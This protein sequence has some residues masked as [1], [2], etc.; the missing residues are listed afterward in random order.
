MMTEWIP[1][2]ARR[3]IEIGARDGKLREE[4]LQIR[5]DCSYLCSEGQ[6]PETELSDRPVDCFFYHSSC[7]QGADLQKMLTHHGE[8]L[9]DGG[10][11]I[12]LLEN[13]GHVK[14]LLQLLGGQSLPAAQR[15]LREL[16][17]ILEKSGFSVVRV[18][19]FAYGEENE[20]RQEPAAEELLQ[21]AGKFA[22]THGLPAP[23]EPWV[24]G[25]VLRAVRGGAPEPMLLQA[26]LGEALVTARVRIREPHR[27]CN[28]IPGVWSEEKDD[29]VQLLPK[30]RFPRRVLIRQRAQFRDR[31][32][33]GQMIRRVAEAGYLMIAEM[34]DSPSRWEENFTRSDYLDFAG[35]HAVQVSTPALRE[36]ILRYQPEVRVFPNQLEKLP[37]PRE[38]A[39]EGA[40]VTIFFGAL[41][42]E[43]EWDDIM[44]VLN[45]AAHRLGDGLRFRVLADAAFYQALDTPCKEF[46][47]RKDYCGGRFVPYPVYLEILRSADI[48]L[49]PLKDNVFNRSKSDLKFIES[50]G[51]G[52]VVLASPTVYADSVRDGQ[53]GFLYRDA[54]EF[55]ERLELLLTDR[56][57]RREMAAVAYDY[58]K[59]HRLLSDHYEERIDWY[60]ELLARLP[61][62]NKALRERLAKIGM[63]FSSR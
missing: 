58:V 40:P 18:A 46:I 31:E 16:M 13:P 10:Q 33:A 4:F 47:G 59:Q 53:T 35:M 32:E 2:K 62:L 50:A 12:F 19:P 39:P 1:P 54:R 14:R 48:A 3:V 37:P 30:E 20:W 7:L 11:M 55:R 41:N 21:A 9:A 25:Y 24:T 5:P 34:D 26:M 44:P 38:Y 43:R 28:T 52:A 49:L 22:G 63:P 61:E 17:E 57:R 45:E 51:N 56:S 42:R 6:P 23:A 27:F 60:N 15:T 8:F 36:E 29:G